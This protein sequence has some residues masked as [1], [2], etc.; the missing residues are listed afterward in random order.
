MNASLKP[1]PLQPL[2]DRNESPLFRRR[3][4]TRE[5]EYLKR[6]NASSPDSSSDTNANELKPL[7]L[8]LGIE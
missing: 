1:G 6:L 2:D 3:A 5:R 7:D 8:S 4:N